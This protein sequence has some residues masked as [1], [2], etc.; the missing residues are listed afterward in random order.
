M[1]ILKKI[2][3]KH[4]KLIRRNISHKG[5]YKE[6]IYIVIQGR[7]YKKYIHSGMREE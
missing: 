4:L 3:E 6:S 1:I 5:K 7:G 2:Y